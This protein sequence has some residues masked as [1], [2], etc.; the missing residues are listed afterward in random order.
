M[1]KYCTHLTLPFLLI[2]SF[3]LYTFIQK[4]K[5][6][7]KEKSQT[8]KKLGEVKGLTWRKHVIKLQVRIYCTC[9]TRTREVECVRSI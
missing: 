5:N 9:T 6:R 8:G 1:Y 3:A 2:L 7:A 4:E